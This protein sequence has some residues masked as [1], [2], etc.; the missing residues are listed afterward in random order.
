M[1]LR[2]RRSINELVNQSQIIS[3]V[4][5]WDWDD[6]ML[7]IILPIIKMVAEKSENASTSLSFFY[8]KLMP[9]RRRTVWKTS[10]RAWY[11]SAVTFTSGKISRVLSPD[12]NATAATSEKK[13]EG[14]KFSLCCP[15]T[16]EQLGGHY[17]R[18]QAFC[19]NVKGEIW[20]TLNHGPNHIFKNKFTLSWFLGKPCLMQYFSKKESE[21]VFNFIFINRKSIIILKET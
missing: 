1:R 4:V 3:G 21:I 9:P 20:T 7:G 12:A 13:R 6:Q 17:F 15:V 5:S 10:T 16:Y 2:D 8:A 14:E 11:S 18:F 19:Q